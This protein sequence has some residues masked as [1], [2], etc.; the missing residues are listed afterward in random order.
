[1][2]DN[3]IAVVDPTNLAAQDELLPDLMNGLSSSVLNR[4]SNMR[5]G[6]GT[7]SP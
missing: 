3:Q 2:S 6:C 1:V 5:G 7:K 4:L